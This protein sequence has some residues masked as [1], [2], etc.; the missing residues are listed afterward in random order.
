MCFAWL[1]P[2]CLSNKDH[3]P[4]WGG[5][6]HQKY[7]PAPV[8]HQNRQDS[9]KNDAAWRSD[10]A[11]NILNWMYT[12]QLLQNKNNRTKNLFLYLS[13]I[14]YT[15]FYKK[16]F[17]KK[18]LIMKGQK[19][20]NILRKSINKSHYFYEILRKIVKNEE[21]IHA[22]HKKVDGMLRAKLS[23]TFLTFWG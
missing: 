6:Q 9:H 8:H 19:I 17:H 7:F 3:H 4:H 10:V 2:Y 18:V 15:L 16:V 22:F 1:F 20:R 13:K 5:N 23:E 21:I 11:V 14:I 12:K